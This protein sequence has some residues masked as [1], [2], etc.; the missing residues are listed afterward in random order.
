M[1][2]TGGWAYFSATR[3]IL[4]IRPGFDCLEIAPCIPSGWSEFHVVREWRESRYEIT[5]KNPDG[6]MKGVMDLYLDG[7]KVEKIAFDHQSQKQT[8]QVLVVMGKRTE[9]KEGSL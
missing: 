6:V 2:G 5:V 8:H 7:E 1:T 4:G 3:Y 9:K